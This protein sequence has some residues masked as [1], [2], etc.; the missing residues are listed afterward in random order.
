MEARQSEERG[1][2]NEIKRVEM[3]GLGEN[4]LVKEDSVDGK[5]Q[6]KGERIKR[7]N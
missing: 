5:E 7:K 1:K 3:D 2:R 4:R 6:E